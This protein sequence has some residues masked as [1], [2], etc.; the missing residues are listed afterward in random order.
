MIT[1]RDKQLHYLRL[2]G[3]KNIKTLIIITLK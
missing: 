3:D 1:K 2:R